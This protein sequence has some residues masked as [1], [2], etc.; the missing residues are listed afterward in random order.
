MLYSFS[1]G[2]GGGEGALLCDDALPSRKLLFHW[3]LLI[4]SES[5]A[6]TL[7]GSFLMLATMRYHEQQEIHV[8][9]HFATHL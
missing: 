3:P 1:F 6:S 7:A 2:G 4:F 9:A 8:N 5:T